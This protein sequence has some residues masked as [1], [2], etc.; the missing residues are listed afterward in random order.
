M[1]PAE[2]S[3]LVLLGGLGI[4]ALLGGL[5]VK[6]GFATIASVFSPVLSG[7][8]LLVFLLIGAAELITPAYDRTQNMFISKIPALVRAFLLAGVIA[9][10]AAIS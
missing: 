2:E 5:L 3:L 8:N 1:K 9:G 6:A 7:S 10:I 4:Y